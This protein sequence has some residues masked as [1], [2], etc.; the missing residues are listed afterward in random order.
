MFRVRPTFVSLA[1]SRSQPAARRLPL[2]FRPTPTTLSK[3]CASS[4]S[5]PSILL[6]IR[7][8]SY[9]YGGS[10][11]HYRHGKATGTRSKQFSCTYG[12]RKPLGGRRKPCKKYKMK[13]HQGAAARWM[14]LPGGHF[15]RRQVGVNHKNSKMRQWKRHSKRRRVL[16]TPQQRRRLKKLIPYWNKP[17]M[18]VTKV[19][20]T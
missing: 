1:L 6:P 13:T 9:V 15:Y 18:Q 17:Y 7:N 2:S 11:R 10:P 20:Y 12:K 14:V 19:A 5:P 16:A 3:P 8:K 4:P